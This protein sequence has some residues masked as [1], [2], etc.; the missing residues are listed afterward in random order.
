LVV[1]DVFTLWS[2]LMLERCQRH[3]PNFMMSVGRL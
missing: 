2:L 1:S 3:R